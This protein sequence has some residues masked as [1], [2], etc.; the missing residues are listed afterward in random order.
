MPAENPLLDPSD[1]PYQLPPFDRIR[2]EHFGDAFAEALTEHQ[3]EVAIIAANDEPPSFANT[4]EALERSGQMLRRVGLAFF[5]LTAADATE[6]IEA[7][8]AELAPKLT[9]H[10]DAI[11]LNTELFARIDQVS[12][13]RD[14]LDL[15]DEEAWLLE[16]THLDFVRAGAAL[17]G[18]DREQLKQ[19]NTNLSELETAFQ[20]RMLAGQNAAAL[21][22][23]D[24]A[25]LAGLSDDE[26]DAAAQAAKERG[27][28]GAY[29]I[30]LILPTDQPALASLENRQVRR[31][32]LAASQTRGATG[33]EHDTASLVPRIARLRAERA[34]LLG[35][36]THA[37]YE[38]ADQT[39]GTPHAARELLEQL[40]GPAVTRAA[41]DAA[42]LAELAAADGI[43]E[44]EAWD[45]QFYAERLREQRYAFSGAQLREYFE[46]EHVLSEGVFHAAEQ[47]YG[48]TLQR[49]ND[50]PGYHPDVRIYEVFDGDGSELGLFVADFYTRPTKRGGAWMNPLVEQSHLLGTKPVVV[51]NYNFTRPAEGKP[52]LLTYDEVI[53]LFHEFGHALHGLFSDVRYTRFSGTSV[54]RDFV[55]F[56]SQVNEM[57]ALWPE[58]L[59]NY[60][61]HYR[62]GAPMPPEL[63]ENVRTSEQFNQAQDVVR[64]W[65][66][67]CSILRGTSWNPGTYPTTSPR[68]KRRLW[69]LL[70]WMIRGF[71][72]GTAAPT[73]PTRSSVGT[74]PA[75]T[76]TC[77]VRSWTR[78]RSPGSTRREA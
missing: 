73:S 50:L 43:E 17:S 51:N 45:W 38:I 28:D 35:F 37:A 58:V 2:P 72:R 53:T 20:R 9:A 63:L 74:A 57:W 29:A 78:T 5:N 77:G 33:G 65:P 30:T 4:V 70:A 19:L 22:V 1:L 55:E 18:A 68:S 8:Q 34:R 48:I 69:A 56:P 64:T 3:A 75:T 76:R 54:P 61:K 7:L 27:H 25:D 71:R 60:A 31:Q 44:L 11:Y 67:H 24:A 40:A 13:Q 26:I 10:T 59:T 66:P 42:V 41:D 16:R 6:T 47:L 23:D 46:L 49:R 36:N 62:T 14:Q 21:I 32:L 12:T 15:S 39:A 52:S